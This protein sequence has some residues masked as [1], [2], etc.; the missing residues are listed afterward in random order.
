[1]H[2]TSPDRIY[3]YRFAIKTRL[4]QQRIASILF[5]YDKLIEANNNRIKILE[6]MAENLYKEWFVRFRFPSHETAEFENGIPKGWN[7]KR[8]SSFGKI[9]T[10][11]TPSTEKVENYGDDFLFVKTPEMHGK[12]FVIDTEEKLSFLGHNTQPKKLLPPNSI[13]VS[14]IGSGGIVALNAVRAHTNQQINS[15]VADIFRS[16]CKQEKEQSTFMPT[17]H[18]TS[19]GNAD[20]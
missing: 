4:V 8:L 12:T 7:I 13:M 6:Q 1:M 15:I 20:C 11:K 10:G 18:I 9:E 3:K 14:C 2:H 19:A 16:K 17:A 5:E